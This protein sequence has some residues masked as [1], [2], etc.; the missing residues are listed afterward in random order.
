MAY[1]RENIEKANAYQP[2]FQPEQTDDVVKLNT[3]ENPYPP[4]PAVLQA[5]KAVSPDQLRRYPDPLA[6]AFR[7]AAAFQ[8][9]ILCAAM[10]QMSCL[11]SPSVPFATKNA[12]LRILSPRIHFIPYWQISRIVA[13]LKSPSIASLISPPN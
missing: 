12:P 7:R 9:I 11:P 1:F 13:P 2:G 5:V 10:G 3:N 8:L 4:S 6:N